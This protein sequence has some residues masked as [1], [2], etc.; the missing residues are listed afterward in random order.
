MPIQPPEPMKLAVLPFGTATPS[1]LSPGV[2]GCAPV[3][4]IARPA[5]AEKRVEF[6]IG[7]VA[8]VMRPG[9]KIDYM[10]ILESIQGEKKST[11]GEVLAGQWF[12]DSLPNIGTDPVRLSL[13]PSGL[14]VELECFQPAARRKGDNSDPALSGLSDERS[15]R[16]KRVTGPPGGPVTATDAEC[17]RL[18]RVLCE[19]ARSPRK[20]PAFKWES[21]K[22]SPLVKDALRFSVMTID[23]RTD[24]KPKV[25]SRRRHLR[26]QRR[27]DAGVSRALPGL[28]NPSSRSPPKSGPFSASGNAIAVGKWRV[29]GGRFGIQD[30]GRSGVTT[31]ARQGCR[32]GEPG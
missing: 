12:S 7:M 18:R 16:G 24:E 5:A 13:R 26:S 8:R 4:I 3:L 20:L 6:L 30:C 23:A 21:R 15:H 31:L 9:C 17:R 10:L 11:I 14:F 29:R 28:A 32:A 22:F 19:R 1:S 27:H 2:A 25:A